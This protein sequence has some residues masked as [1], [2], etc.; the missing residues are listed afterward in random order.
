M[1]TE[2]WNH[3]IHYHRLLLAAVPA[4]GRVL[5]VGCGEGML[6]REVA[7]RAAH[8]LGV[9]LDR[10]SIE[11]A[12]ATTAQANVEYRCADVLVDAFDGQV[13]D[14]VVSVATLH[15]LGTR[16][17]LQRMAA[18]L[19]PGGVLGVVGLASSR[20]PQ[21][22]PWEIAAAIGT[23]LLKLRHTYWEHA[24]PKVWNSPD[25]YGSVRRIASECLPGASFRRLLLWRYI[26]LWQ[27]PQGLGV[28]GALAWRGPWRGGGE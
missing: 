4:G 11:L 3:N 18:L 28:A 9:D 23:R 13:F 24:A 10:P 1:S 6:T 2:R 16:A 19:R 22:L 27:K 17:G 14:A 12:R 26:L 21:D 7:A 25:D 8:V 15:H 5:D 20:L